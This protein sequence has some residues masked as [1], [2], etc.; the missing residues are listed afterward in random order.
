MKRMLAIIVSIIMMTSV[1]HSMDQSRIRVIQT[2][3]DSS[4]TQADLNLASRMLFDMWDDEVKQRER[5]I[6]TMLP[7]GFVKKFKTSM[8]SLR[9]HVESMSK[10]RSELFKLDLTEP[11]YY[12]LNGIDS[13]LSSIRRANRMKPYVYNMSKAIYYEEKWIELDIL[14]NTR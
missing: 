6:I 13:K 5:D 4:K 2:M 12:K 8:R 3:I 9:I 14:L 11:R 10:I 1:S 7:K